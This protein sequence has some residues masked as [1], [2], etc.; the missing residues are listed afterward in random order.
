M[1]NTFIVPCH[2]FVDLITNSS[3]ELFI[4]NTDKTEE[5]LYK[6]II[7]VLLS[8]NDHYYN[9]VVRKESIKIRGINNLEKFFLKLK[10]DKKLIQIKNDEYLYPIDINNIKEKNDIEEMF[11][12]DFWEDAIRELREIY[13]YP[14]TIKKEGVEE[15]VY[16]IT[17]PS[18]YY[19][20]IDEWTLIID[21][22]FQLHGKDH[23]YFVE[24]FN[25]ISVT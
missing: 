5:M 19:D 20:N 4:A 3:T 17:F 22:D 18:Y 1:K 13:D 12:T 25:F 9:N 21:L 16:G 14:I 15:K 10:K 6:M 24:N 8:K 7:D 2:S 23:S 11:N